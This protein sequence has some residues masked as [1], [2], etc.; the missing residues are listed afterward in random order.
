MLFTPDHTSTSRSA[1]TTWISK[2][3]T[4]AYMTRRIRNGFPV[5]QYRVVP[6]C[7]IIA[8]GRSRCDR[9]LWKSTIE[10]EGESDTEDAESQRF[11]PLRTK[12]GQIFHALRPSSLRSRRDSTWSLNHPE[13][14]Q[15]HTPNSAESTTTPVL[16]QPRHPLATQIPSPT[17]AKAHPLR[18]ISQV[19]S[20]DSFRRSSSS[21]ERSLAR[22]HSLETSA[23]PAGRGVP[24][25]HANT[26]STVVPTGDG[27][28]ASTT[29]VSSPLQ[30]PSSPDIISPATTSP[31]PSVPKFRWLLPFFYRDGSNQ[32]STQQ[33][34]PVATATPQ[35]EPPPPRRGDVVCLK[36]DTLDDRGMRRLEGR[37]D[38]RPV[39]GSYAVY[40]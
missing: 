40:I 20:V 12:M 18:R 31:S 2:R 1:R 11:V 8:D 39:I 35:P 38:H 34:D 19:R 5:G 4:K 26:I 9:I 22:V 14:P 15:S 23:P 33:P 25:R 37:S 6:S 32:Q 29:L 27:S 16:H 28:S 3:R 17:R 24:L 7:R 30:S 36:Y 13:L 10:P 21:D